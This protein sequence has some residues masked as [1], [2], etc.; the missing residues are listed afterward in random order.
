MNKTTRKAKR[1]GNIALV[2]LALKKG[3]SLAEVKA[4]IQDV[5]DDTWEAPSQELVQLFPNG[6]PA[7]ALFIGIIASQV[8]A[9]REIGLPLRFTLSKAKFRFF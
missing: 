9:A 2:L 8:A 3:W 7:P 6:K 5:I 4:E 1:K